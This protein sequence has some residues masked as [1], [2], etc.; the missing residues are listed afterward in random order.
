MSIAIVDIAIHQYYSAI[1]YTH[2]DHSHNSIKNNMFMNYN[3]SGHNNHMKNIIVI[4][5][6]VLMHGSYL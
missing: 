6:I 5:M 3:T 2:I 1:E 4:G